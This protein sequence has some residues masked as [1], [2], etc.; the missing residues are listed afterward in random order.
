[1]SVTLWIHHCWVVFDLVYV[2]NYH[3]G[4][5]DGRQSLLRHVRYALV[6]L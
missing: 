1:M 5:N 3:E 6:T 2:D 4:R